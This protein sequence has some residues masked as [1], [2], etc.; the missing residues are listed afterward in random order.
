M[1]KLTIVISGS[2]QS[3]RSTLAK[4]IICEYLNRKMKYKRF[5]LEKVDDVILIKDSLNGQTIYTEL[6]N[7]ASKDLFDAHSV[8]IYSFFDPLRKICTDVLGLDKEQCYDSFDDKSSNTHL[9]WD[10]LPL[11]VREKYSRARR[12]T[13]GM[14]PAHG[15]MTSKEV[16]QVL[17]TDI[18]R[19]LDNSCWARALYSAIENEGYELAIVLDPSHP[20]DI[21]I[22]MENGAKTIRLTKNIH[23]TVDNLSDF[24]LGEYSLVIYNKDLASQQTYNK[25]KTHLLDWFEQ[26]K[27]V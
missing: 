18:F 19:R 2:R 23:D 15:F 8:K 16:L 6:Q 20:S 5:S 4:F 26:R 13:G 12:G 24:A 22:G 1:N 7:S 14:K 9:L 25:L 17:D 27:L 11:E 3:G 10:D 21:T